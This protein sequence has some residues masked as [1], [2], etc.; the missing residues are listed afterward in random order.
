MAIRSIIIIL[1]FIREQA[2]MQ[3]ETAEQVAR[4]LVGFVR[5]LTRERHPVEAAVEDFLAQGNIVVNGVTKAQ[6]AK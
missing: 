5:L 3:A 2:V 4:G 1:K 6:E